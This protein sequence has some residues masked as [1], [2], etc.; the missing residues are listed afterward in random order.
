MIRR[1][2]IIIITSKIQGRIKFKLLLINNLQTR[3]KT[4][5]L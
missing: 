5:N 2:E 4:N 1:I 3:Q